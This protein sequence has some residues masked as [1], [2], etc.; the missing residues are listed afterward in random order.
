[1]FKL[2]EGA[3]PEWLGYV[4]I[5][6]GLGGIVLA[7]LFYVTAPGIPVS[8]G[9]TFKGI[10]TVLYNKYF[11]DELYDSTVVSPLVDGSRSL[12]WRVGD[13]AIIDGAVNGIGKVAAATGSLLRM[14]QSGY[15]RNYAAWVV[16]GAILAIGWIGLRVVAK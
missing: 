7:Y 10:Y 9:R 8:I 14:A 16:V 6:A 2:D 3:I 11:V 13:V 15:I 4:A 5:A 12:L 1:M